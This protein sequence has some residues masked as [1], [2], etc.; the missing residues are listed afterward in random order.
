MLFIR[1]TDIPKEA[2]P[3]YDRLPYEEALL[4]STQVHQEA[5]QANERFS[6]EFRIFD[7]DDQLVYKGT[8]QFGDTTYPNLYQQLKERI[9][10]IR[11]RKEDATKKILLLENLERLTPETYKTM[12]TEAVTRSNTDAT[13]IS[14]LRR[15]QRRIVY[16]ASGVSLLLL[17]ALTVVRLVQPDLPSGVRAEASG[18]RP[19]YEAALTGE[20]GPLVENLEKR[21]S[22]N[23]EQQQF[24]IT[25][26][27]EEQD[28]DQAVSV[29]K[30]PIDVETIIMQSKRFATNRQDTL[31][32]F[33]AVHPT[34]EGTFDLAILQKDYRRAVS[35]MD[36]EMTTVRQEARTRAYIAL[37]DV[38]KAKESVRTVQDEKLKEQVATF[39][40]LD[41]EIKALENQKRQLSEKED[42]EA[43]E[44]LNESLEA[45]QR[46]LNMI[47]K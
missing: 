40:R 36:V 7:D 4:L 30:D 42:K 25:H 11:I 8:F 13:H 3:N 32:S 44:K 35:L 9:P 21:Q 10:N 28:Y 27:V 20:T 6:S 34:D 31:Q 1:F 29:T 37:K 39:V 33:Q 15:G 12:V 38:A 47:I 23:D 41:E 2:F 19:L 45:K 17:G 18:W 14:R 43:L 26:Y 5:Q 24:L 46:Q 16:G 22:L